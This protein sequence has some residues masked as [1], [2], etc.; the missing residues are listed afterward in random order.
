MTPSAVPAA[1]PR[2][3]RL[4]L[5]DRTE[6]SPPRDGI[7]MVD[8]PPPPSV[9][10]TAAA[11]VAPPSRPAPPPVGGDTI[12]TGGGQH[13]ARGVQGAAVIFT[14][15][16]AAA[17]VVAA[18]GAIIELFVLALLVLP[19]LWPMQAGPRRSSCKRIH[20]SEIRPPGSSRAA[21]MGVSAWVGGW[22]GGG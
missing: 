5:E 22:V 13:P 20:S 19:L 4:T 3:C 21:T 14:F 16:A 6:H 17:A 11:A 10:T 1:G 9:F 15:A 8:P 12:S 18:D 2:G 7:P